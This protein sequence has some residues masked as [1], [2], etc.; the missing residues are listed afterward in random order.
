MPPVSRRHFL[1]VAGLS[2]PVARLLAQD[3][4]AE[5]VILRAMKDELERSRQLRVVGGSG[6]DTPYFISYT[7]D[8]ND[9][10]EVDASFGAVTTTARNRFRL[11]NIEVRVGSYDFDNTGHIFSGLY[12][13]SRYDTD[14]LPLDNDYRTLREGLWLGTDYA[15]KAAVESIARKRA[16]LTNAAAPTDK[17][18]DYTRADKFES[19][20]KITRTKVDEAAWGARMAKHSAIFNAY[21]EV[22]ASGV[23][24]HFN[25]DTTYYLDT[26]GTALRYPDDVAW[27]YARAEGQSPDGM[28]L[29]DTLATPAF[30]LSTLPSEQETDA[31]LTALARN[32]KALAQAPAGEAYVGPVLFE[33]QAA[34]QLLAQLLGD[35]LH[36]PRKPVSD[37]S[38]P[39]N[40]IASEYE[41]RT[42][43]RVL[44]E[45]LD[46]VDDPTQTTYQGKTLTG[47]YPFDFEGV[48]PKPV[49]VIEKGVLKTFLTTR[50]PTKNLPS[51]NG[52][53]RFPVGFGTRGASIGNLFV[54][55]AQSTPLVD[56]K[57]RLMQMCKE[58]DKPYGLLIRK[59]DFPFS[60]GNADVQMLRNSSANSGGSQ[61]PVSPPVLLY[62]VYPD[63][64][65]ELVRGM[66]FKGLSTRSLRDILAAS[67]ETTVFDYINNGAPLARTGVGGYI[68]L[69]SVISPGLLFDEL[70]VDRLQ[71]QLQKPPLVPPPDRTAS[72]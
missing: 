70:E 21:P 20:A 29:R 2:V 64:R 28:V 65:E 6:D 7:L 71:D 52:H 66:G 53:A 61:R 5:D 32:I 47:Y 58:R 17:L 45:W 35:N 34:A 62:R 16:A 4:Y 31:S 68:A 15:Y 19:L 3:P 10:F 69:T 8:D 56:L 40:V 14:P 24:F 63:G 72:H 9:A 26:E 23:E 37:P 30:T 22:L 12:S 33:P 43:S 44:P 48:K 55:P 57:T 59:L 42:G 25:Q 46:V 54:K 50:Q 36:I 51:S 27:I 18:P 38:R 60:G 1:I 39:V 41:G 49:T 11:P 13:G 67:A